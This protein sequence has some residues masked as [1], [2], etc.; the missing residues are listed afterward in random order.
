MSRVDGGGEGKQDDAK[1]KAAEEAGQS[2]SKGGVSASPTDSL[3]D[4]LRYLNLREDEEEDVV[5]EEDLEELEIALSSWRWLG[6]I[7]IETSA[8]VLSMGQ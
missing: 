1:A 4:K 7:P 6:F 8:M 3:N 5:L 2:S